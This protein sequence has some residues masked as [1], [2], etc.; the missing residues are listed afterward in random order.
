MAMMLASIA[1]RVRRF[2]YLTPSSHVI[3]KNLYLCNRYANKKEVL[4]L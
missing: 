2:A 1:E 4:R 3:E